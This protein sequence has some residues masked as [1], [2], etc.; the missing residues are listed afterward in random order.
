MVGRDGEP[1]AGMALLHGPATPDQLVDKV[2]QILG[3][4][5]EAGG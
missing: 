5:G 2:R 3:A 4:M 1:D